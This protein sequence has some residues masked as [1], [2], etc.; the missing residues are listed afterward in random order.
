[1]HFIILQF[2]F[3]LFF[4]K[5]S[6]T[7]M[8]YIIAL[9]DK[10]QSIFFLKAWACLLKAWACIKGMSLP[11]YILKYQYLCYLYKRKF[12]K[13]GTFSLSVPTPALR[14]DLEFSSDG[15]IFHDEL[16]CHCLVYPNERQRGW[17]FCYPGLPAELEYGFSVRLFRST[18]VRNSWRNICSSQKTVMG[19][20]AKSPLKCF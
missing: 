4:F 14:N 17:N 2:P 15:F 5:S 19:P 8:L 16:Y 3:Y 10:K 13:F 11:K 18:L 9:G 20:R 7:L 12:A 6:L 1:M